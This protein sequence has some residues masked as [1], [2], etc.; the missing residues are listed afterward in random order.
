MHGFVADRTGLRPFMWRDLSYFEG[1][2]TSTVDVN[3]CLRFEDAPRE[4]NPMP[5]PN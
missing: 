3:M 4:P 2:G 5:P 1:L